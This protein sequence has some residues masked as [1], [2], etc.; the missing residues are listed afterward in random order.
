VLSFVVTIR[1]ISMDTVFQ[2]MEWLT[3]YPAIFSVGALVLS[4]LALKNSRRA[5]IVGKKPQ[6]VF[7][8]ELTPIIDGVG[9]A[10]RF[11]LVNMGSGSAFNVKIPNEYIQ[12]HYFLQALKEIPRNI[13]PGGKTLFYEA[14]GPDPLI[15]KQDLVLEVHYE[16]HEGRRYKTL[17]ENREHV[18]SE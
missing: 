12:R 1:E 16:D 17:L 15:I 8:E 11:Y 18:F 13:G 10:S 14:A 3:R 4:M 5:T 2:I 7:N 9:Y 6:L